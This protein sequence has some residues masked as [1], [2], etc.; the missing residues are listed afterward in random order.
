MKLP[1]L[2]M[3]LF[4]LAGCVTPASQT[5]NLHSTF[6]PDEAKAML[7]PGNNKIIGSALIRQ[8]GGGIVTCAGTEVVLVPATQY[9]KERIMH[10]YGSTDRGYRPYQQGG[11]LTP[12]INFQPDHPTYDENTRVVIGDSQG[13]FEFEN[14]K[15]GEYFISTCIVWGDNNPYRRQGGCLIKREEIKGGETKRVILSP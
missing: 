9:A 15:D 2:F 6:D 11:T 5:V 12:Y 3:L 7:E 8:Q 1:I 14:I 10:L 4:V 13:M